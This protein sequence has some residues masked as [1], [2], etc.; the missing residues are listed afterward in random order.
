MA[1]SCC[2]HL[3]WLLEPGFLCS[4]G[5]VWL[6]SG[7]GHQC[8]TAAGGLLALVKTTGLLDGYL[9]TGAAFSNGAGFAS[10]YQLGL[11][12]TLLP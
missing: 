4:S 2:N 11:L 3:V 1:L 5:V 12:I 6:L 10:Y 8:G 9:V 7:P